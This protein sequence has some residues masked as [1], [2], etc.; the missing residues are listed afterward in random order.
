MQMLNWARSGDKNIELLGTENKTHCGEKS[1]MG[2]TE[3]RNTVEKSQT[4]E[5]KALNAAKTAKYVNSFIIAQTQPLVT[6]TTVATYL[7]II[8]KYQYNM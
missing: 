1:R 3:N 2:G 7:A 6:V 4:N 8:T 5:K